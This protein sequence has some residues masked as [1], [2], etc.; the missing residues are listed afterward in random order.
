MN[1]F[2]NIVYDSLV[3]GGLLTRQRR[4]SPFSHK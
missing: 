1:V 4:K 3:I 2:F